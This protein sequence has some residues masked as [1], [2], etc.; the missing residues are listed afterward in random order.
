V[1][2]RVDVSSKVK[3]SPPARRVRAVLEHA[4]RLVPRSGAGDSRSGAEVSVL[5]C[6][7]KT[8]RTLNRRYRGKDR[9][10]DVLAFPAGSGGLLGDI[11]ISLP[12]AARR[13]RRLGEPPGKEVRRLLLHGLLHLRGYD[14]ET[15]QGEMDG[16][17]AKLRRRLG[18]E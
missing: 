8:M 3:G 1:S 6:G 4:S 2:V 11:V 9:A 5:F 14:H 10:T 18:L 7:D 17:E 15:D 16:L 13:S 12:Y